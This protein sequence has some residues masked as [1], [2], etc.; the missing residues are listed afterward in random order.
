MSSAAIG[1]VRPQ[2]VIPALGIVQILNWGSTYYLPAVLGRQIVNATGWS[3][4]VVIGGLSLGLGVAGLSS[5]HVGRLIERY[6]GRP[7][8]TVASLL[9]A[10]GLGLLAAAP[11]VLCYLGAWV[12]LGFSMGGGLYDAAFSTLGRLYGQNARRAISTLTLWSGFASTICWPLSALMFEHLGWRGTC[13][14]YAMLQILV[15]I[16]L[17]RGFIPETPKMPLQTGSQSLVA[18]AAEPPP[19]DHR[20]ATFVLLSAIL[21]TG[22]TVTALVSV[23]LIAMLQAGGIGYAVAVG[24]S[25]LV[26]PAQVL[27]RVIERVFG[28]TLHPIWIMMMACL[29][30]TV[31]LV[32]LWAGPGVAAV[33]LVAY[34]AG[35]G[36]WSIARG[37]LPLALFGSKG[38]P[39]LMGKLATPMLIAQALSP[40]VGAI[41]LDS[42]GVPVTEGILT[43]VAVLC[44]AGIAALYLV[45]RRSIGSPA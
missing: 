2:L 45:A 18:T 12:V 25:T 29:M 19:L 32:L 22:G 17:V 27:S 11:N 8:L 16:P 7:V 31:G 13:L 9:M 26:G 36:I 34:G 20:T 40:S 38:Y 3:Y 37:T 44:L 30:L 1:A 6:G 41:L 43:G 42:L 5:V 35:A 39:A 21:T 28:S 33:A 14:A 15:C 24:L 4:A 23:H 10:L